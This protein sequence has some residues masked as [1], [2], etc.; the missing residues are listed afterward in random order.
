MAGRP[1][2]SGG[3]NRRSPE[4]HLLHGTWNVTR[5]GPRP[6]APSLA[7][8]F[9]RALPLPTRSQ[10]APRLPVPTVD[11]IS[12]AVL[13]GLTGRGLQLVQDCWTG[14]SG[15]TV[16]SLELLHEAGMLIAALEQ[17]RGVKGERAAQRLLVTILNAL[18]LED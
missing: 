17:Q 5:H 1:G 10:A 3:W 14:Y 7:G 15:W 4:H 6:V 18:N 9:S 16:V 12:P 11:P 13:E 2:R 8:D